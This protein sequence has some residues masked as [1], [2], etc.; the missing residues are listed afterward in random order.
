M[1][2]KRKALKE[3]KVIY[4]A[5]TMWVL[6]SPIRVEVLNAV[7][8]L[9]ECSVAEIA[10]FTGRSRTSL[11]PHIEQLVDAGLIG[12]GQRRHGGAGASDKVI[13]NRGFAALVG[14]CDPVASAGPCA[15]AGRSAAFQGR[16][17]LVR[18]SPEGG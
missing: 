6:A 18:I 1:S 4:D 9:E 16:S 3:L 10:E 15:D 8:T 5:Q 17:P 14:P 12:A 2:K 11:Y 13:D 7:C